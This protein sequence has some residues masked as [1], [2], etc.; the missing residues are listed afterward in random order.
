[1]AARTEEDVILQRNRRLW[2]EDRHEWVGFSLGRYKKKSLLLGLIG[3]S[4]E[5][6]KS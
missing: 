1:M 6:L 5:K 2:E 3:I 4:E